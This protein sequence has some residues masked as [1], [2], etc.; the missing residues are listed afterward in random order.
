[1]LIS[2]SPG[3]PVFREVVLVHD[4][5]E[6]PLPEEEAASNSMGISSNVKSRRL[7]NSFMFGICLILLFILPESQCALLFTASSIEIHVLYGKQTTHTV[8]VQPDKSGYCKS[9]MAPN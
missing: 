2:T 6:F 1:M 9:Q 4:S 5:C 8:R 7:G 3:R